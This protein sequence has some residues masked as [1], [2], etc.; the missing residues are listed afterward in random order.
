MVL[1]FVCVLFCMFVLSMCCSVAYAGLYMLEV[2]KWEGGADTMPS[3]FVSCSDLGVPAFALVRL[4]L[5]M[6]VLG[7]RF[8]HV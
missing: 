7:E 5:C 3:F 2:G 1:C 6:N 8:V 4:V